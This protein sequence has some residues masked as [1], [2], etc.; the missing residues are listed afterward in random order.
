MVDMG[1]GGYKSWCVDVTDQSKRF[2][3]NAESAFH[4][5]AYRNVGNVLAQRV[6]EKVV[7]LMA[8]IVSDLFAK[9]A[10]ADAQSNRFSHHGNSCP[11]D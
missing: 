4:F 9:K 11:A 7:P 1:S 8:A 6:N 5:R 2:S 3:R 10:C